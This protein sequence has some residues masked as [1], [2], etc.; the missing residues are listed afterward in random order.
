ML[1]SEFPKPFLAAIQSGVQE[2]AKTGPIAGFPMVDLKVTAL[3]ANLHPVDSSEMA[4]NIA[5]LRCFGDAAKAAIP[6]LLEP[7][8]ELE[9]VVP[10]DHV[11]DVVGDL[12]ARRGKIAGIEAR[13]TGVETALTTRD[14]QFTTVTDLVGA[15]GAPA[16]RCCAVHTVHSYVGTAAH[17]ALAG[18]PQENEGSSVRLRAPDA[19]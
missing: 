6:V 13:L 5:A 18:W 17:S 2:A 11:G 12:H 3:E 15:R 19:E 4:F 7:V 9:V 1:P 8:M 14:F 10:D 16:S